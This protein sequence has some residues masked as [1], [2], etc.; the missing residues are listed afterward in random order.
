MGSTTT[1]SRF[2]TQSKSAAQVTID[3][4]I[5]QST[6]YSDM[7]RGLRCHVTSGIAMSGKMPTT[8]TFLELHDRAMTTT[9]PSTCMSRATNQYYHTFFVILPQ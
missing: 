6:S 3:M 8:V 9:M 4:C 2:V 1:S 5:D 7:P